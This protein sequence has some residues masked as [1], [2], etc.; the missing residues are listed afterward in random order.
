MA[1]KPPLS[2][3]TNALELLLEDEGGIII[4]KVILDQADG[5]YELIATL[6]RQRTGEFAISL[7]WLKDKV[8]IALA[9]ELLRLLSSLQSKGV[10]HGDSDAGEKLKSE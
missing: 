8:S 1:I 3:D 4:R 2:I 6:R 7:H 9:E 5:G 10:W